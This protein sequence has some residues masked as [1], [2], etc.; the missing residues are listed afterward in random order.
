MST[1]ADILLISS[2]ASFALWILSIFIKSIRIKQ[3]VRYYFYFSV[4]LFGLGLTFGWSDFKAG[5]NGAKC[6]VSETVQFENPEIY[7]A[8]LIDLKSVASK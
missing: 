8:E 5:L 3:K 6:D 4:L 2:I 7:A 1:L